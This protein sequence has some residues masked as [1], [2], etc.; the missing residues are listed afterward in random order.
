MTIQMSCDHHGPNQGIPDNRSR[1]RMLAQLTAAT[2]LSDSFADLFRQGIS[3]DLRD[4]HPVGIIDLAEA[5]PVME[6]WLAWLQVAPSGDD[7]HPAYQPPA[8]ITVPPIAE[9]P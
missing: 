2:R 7:W 4:G 8:E 9:E 6:A 3:Y 5:I 1:V